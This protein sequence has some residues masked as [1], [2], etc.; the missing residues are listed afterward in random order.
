MS[1]S[2]GTKGK[3]GDLVAIMAGALMW[4]LAPQ[5]PLATAISACALGIVFGY[6]R[7]REL[8]RSSLLAIATSGISLTGTGMVACYAAIEAPYWLP[9][10]AWLGMLLGLC[11]G[12]YERE[13]SRLL[14]QEA[15]G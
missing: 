3:I 5:W 9:W 4:P 13:E 7:R 2:S 1:A 11:A 14:P 10:T 8:P 6:A 15:A 12:W